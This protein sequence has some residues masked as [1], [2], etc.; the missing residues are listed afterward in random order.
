MDAER[1]QC[2][3]PKHTGG[4]PITFKPAFC[5]LEH[6]GLGRRDLACRPA[7]A[8]GYHLAQHG[9]IGCFAMTPAG[10]TCRIPAPALCKARRPWRS[11]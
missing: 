6:E 8:D 2:S 5:E 4:S 1:G 9:L 11:S 10:T 7:F 3:E